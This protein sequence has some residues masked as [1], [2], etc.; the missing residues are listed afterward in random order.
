[1]LYFANMKYENDN[2]NDILSSIIYCLFKY[3]HR[4]IN[5]KIDQTEKKS[6]AHYFVLIAIYIE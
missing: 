2:C 1:M 6:H 5:N 4:L 3:K